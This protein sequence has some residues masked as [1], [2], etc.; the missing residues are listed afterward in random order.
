MRKSFVGLSAAAFAAYFS[1]Q[2]V[3]QVIPPIGL[4]PSSQYQLIF[5]TIDTT[6][7][8]SSD[9]D[10]YNTLVTNEAIAGATVGLPANVTWRAVV[11]TATVNANVN[12][13]S[14]GLPVYNTAG[15]LVASSSIYAG[16]LLTAVV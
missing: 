2:L 11:S 13:V 1:A 8:A 14:N 7:A 6:T 9:I 16:S 3:A 10:D 4:A 15:E 12:A 5:S